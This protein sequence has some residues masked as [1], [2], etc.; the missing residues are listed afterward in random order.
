MDEIDRHSRVSS[1]DVVLAMGLAVVL[2]W[3]LSVAF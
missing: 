1:V 2:V 3:A